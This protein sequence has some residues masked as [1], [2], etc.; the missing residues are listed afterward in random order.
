MKMT[1]KQLIE[2]I[3]YLEL[4]IGTLSK[5]LGELRLRL[6]SERFGFA[7]GDRVEFDR[8]KRRCVGV[9]IYVSEFCRTPRLS[10]ELVQKNG[11]RRA[12]T[13]YHWDNPR[14]VD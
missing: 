14:K 8:G 11:K 10:V 4:E 1:M 12:K 3:A 2:R 5:E 6:D 7:V 9:V 13:V